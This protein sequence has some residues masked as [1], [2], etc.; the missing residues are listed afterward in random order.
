M[1]KFFFF[2]W[3]IFF[4]GF[5]VDFFLWVLF[6]TK[7]NSFLTRLKIMWVDCHVPR[8]LNPIWVPEAP[9]MVL[10]GM[11]SNL[12]ERGLRCGAVYYPLCNYKDRANFVINTKHNIKIIYYTIHRKHSFK[13]YRWQ[14]AFV[15]FWFLFFWTISILC[16]NLTYPRLGLKEISLSDAW[17]LNLNSMN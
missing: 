3:N 15:T 5:F 9:N 17:N 16:Y 14:Y 11:V 1:Y 8:I 2:I 7:T 4:F 10:Y 6:L 13:V 12:Y